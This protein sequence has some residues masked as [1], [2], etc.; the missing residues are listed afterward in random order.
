LERMKWIGP[1]VSVA[2]KK[3][4]TLRKGRGGNSKG[5]GALRAHRDWGRLAADQFLQKWGDFW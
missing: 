2:S 4:F 1:D 5:S 3:H